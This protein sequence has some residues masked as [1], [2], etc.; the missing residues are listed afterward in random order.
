MAAAVL[1]LGAAYLVRVRALGLVGAVVA[2]AL[3][4]AVCLAAWWVE[5][6]AKVTCACPTLE[7]QLGAVR[8]DALTPALGRI[9][10]A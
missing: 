5:R 2:T 6:E 7:N 4:A 9:G 1:G 8:P 10:D 3:A